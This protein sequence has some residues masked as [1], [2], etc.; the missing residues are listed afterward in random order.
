MHSRGPDYGIHHNSAQHLS[1]RVEGRTAYAVPLM[2]GQLHGTGGTLEKFQSGVVLIF[3][4][5]SIGRRDTSIYFNWQKLFMFLVYDMMIS[6]MYA[7]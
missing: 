1:R 5:I 4:E 2:R 7:L 6:R 3:P